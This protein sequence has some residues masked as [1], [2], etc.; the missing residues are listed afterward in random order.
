MSQK[1]ETTIDINNAV[2]FLIQ[3]YINI[4]RFYLYMYKKER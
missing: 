1:Y 4:I 3:K 2:S